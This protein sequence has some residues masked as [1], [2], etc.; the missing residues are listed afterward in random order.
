[1]FPGGSTW[2]APGLWERDGPVS[3]LRRDTAQIPTQNARFN[4]NSP[5]FPRESRC[6]TCSLRKTAAQ[7]PSHPQT[8]PRQGGHAPPGEQGASGNVTL[9]TYLKSKADGGEDT[10]HR[11]PGVRAISRQEQMV[12][13][14][15]TQSSLQLERIFFGSTGI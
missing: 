3:I 1:L 7:S 5:R 15:S 10:K 9:C 6:H 11:G 12:I 14:S 2:A 4:D 13:K 8:S